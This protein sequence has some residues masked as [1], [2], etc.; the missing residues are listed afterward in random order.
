MFTSDSYICFASREDGCCNVVLPLREVPCFVLLKHP[1]PFEPKCL[2]L[3]YVAQT[4]YS[5]PDK[6]VEK[7][8]SIWCYVWAQNGD[9]VAGDMTW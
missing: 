4:K 8:V 9:T 2:N 6:L 1:V 5:R 3:L 7:E